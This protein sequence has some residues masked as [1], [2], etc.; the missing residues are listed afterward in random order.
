MHNTHSG[1]G[2]SPWN[3]ANDGKV[4]NSGFQIAKNRLYV[5]AKLS[6]IGLFHLETFINA[7]QC[8]WIK[9]AF[10]NCNDNWKYDIVTDSNL[11]LNM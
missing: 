2:I 6:G 5:S 3:R 11:N 10:E 4:C 7:L 1:Q 9:C 8:T